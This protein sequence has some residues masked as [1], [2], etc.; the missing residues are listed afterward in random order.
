MLKMMIVDDEIIVRNDF[1]YMINSSKGA[2]KIVAEASNGKEALEKFWECNPDVVIT[3]I[4]MPL[5]N[6]IELAKY[7][8]NANKKTRVILLSSYGEFH[9]AQQAI[10]LG[11]Y[12]YLLKHEIDSNFIV[13]QLSKLSELIKQET[14][15]ERSKAIVELLQNKIDI[16]VENN[17]V[18][19]YDLA[20]LKK[21]FFLILFQLDNENKDP[22]LVARCTESDIINILYDTAT[23]FIQ[24]ES[25]QLSDS[26]VIYVFRIEGTAS[27]YQQMKG[28]T[29]LARTIQM[30]F[31]KEYQIIATAAVGGPSVPRES[32]LKL[33]TQTKAKLPYKIF[34]RDQAVI[35][36]FPQ[37]SADSSGLF[38]QKAALDKLKYHFYQGEYEQSNFFLKKILIEDAVER[39]DL[40]MLN[41]AVDGLLL[42]IRDYVAERNSEHADHYDPYKLRDEVYL[43][44]NVYRIFEW[45]TLLLERLREEYSRRYT[46]KILK[47]MSYI[48]SHFNKE[49]GLEE[50]SRVM[51]VSPIYSSQ[52]FKK[53]VGE[54]FT[55]YLTKYR[56]KSATELLRTGSYKVYEIGD[57]VGYRST[58]YFC[59]VFKQYTGK[60][61]SDYERGGLE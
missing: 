31:K 42:F 14:K 3:D 41:K 4:K 7:I 29:E 33:Y 10:D 17:I 61:P 23:P 8:L 48:H 16:V 37:I 30:K 54:S 50:I 39:K 27:E 45:F 55:T 52:L 5:M 49:I 1:K 21:S 6:G 57:M 38:N 15:A 18:E 36:T 35:T 13:D 22:S 19:K 34:Y 9:L 40:T 25:A 53:E 60:N 32:L 12:S 26:E 20:I 28:I 2:Y 46:Q 43:L 24:W 44:G 56:I 59:R 58:A 51:D 47:A 11:V